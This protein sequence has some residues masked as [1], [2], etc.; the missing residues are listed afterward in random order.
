[1]PKDVSGALIPLF[2]KKAQTVL[3]GYEIDILGDSSFSEKY[4]ANNE[5]VGGYTALA[6]KRGTITSEDGTILNEVE[7]GL[8]NVGLDFKSYV[9]GGSLERK[10]VKINLLF[11]SSNGSL[12]GTVLLYWGIMDA[13]KGDE[14]WVT[15]TV[16]PFEMLDREYPKRIYQIGCNWRFCEATTCGLSLSDY[17]YN[18]TLSAE[19]NGTLLTIAHGQLIDYFVPGYA[20]IIDGDY[21]GEVR[22]IASNGTG[23][24][25]VRVSFG[26][27]IP[28]GTAIKLQK[29]CAKN[30]DACQNI[31][32]NYD[33]YGGFPHVPKQPII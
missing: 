6:V 11:V 23:D 1:M 22:P 2:Y 8:D 28:S 9:L 31:F 26:H 17:D 20:E 12:Q 25:T 14:N 27:T 33:A 24:A 18:G 30:P 4:V 21:V 10:E 32:S 15:V 29:L 13:P 19:S 7:I 3:T 16:R 5:D